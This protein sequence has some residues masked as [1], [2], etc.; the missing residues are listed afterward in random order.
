MPLKYS[1]KESQLSVKSTFSI[2]FERLTDKW[3]EN[4]RVENDNLKKEGQNV[5]APTLTELA[6]YL[7][8]EKIQF[9]SQVLSQYRKGASTPPIDSLAQIAQKLNVSSDYLLGLSEKENYDVKAQ[10]QEAV[11]SCDAE[12]QIQATAAAEFLGLSLDAVKCF[13]DS[14]DNAE[15]LLVKDGGDVIYYPF[16]F[17]IDYLRGFDYSYQ[18]IFENLLKLPEWKAFLAEFHH[19]LCA[20]MTEKVEN[21]FKTKYPSNA[22]FQMLDG[23]K[24][25]Q[26]LF[27]AELNNRIDLL[28]EALKESLFEEYLEALKEYRKDREREKA[29]K[30][31]IKILEQQLNDCSC[32][33]VFR[34]TLEMRL[35][36]V[37]QE[38]KSLKG[39]R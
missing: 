20:Q 3:I 23:N 15:R 10:K 25:Q 16:G 38:L 36:D 2:R 7:S 26:I 6:A 19:L 22:D 8:S 9:S 31:S 33:E 34:G 13:A 4:K 28:L 24:Q 11:K 35:A 14:M 17:V 21:Y 18:H 1:E 5:P 32:N 12:E 29:I 37:K 27:R 30:E 39:Y